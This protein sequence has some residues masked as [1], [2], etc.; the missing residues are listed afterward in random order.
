MGDRP[1][2]GSY[3]QVPKVPEVPVRLQHAIA[4]VVNANAF[5]ALSRDSRLVHD[6]RDEMVRLGYARR[7]GPPWEGRIKTKE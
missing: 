5:A 6:L 4:R 3:P 7:V 1:F 2:S